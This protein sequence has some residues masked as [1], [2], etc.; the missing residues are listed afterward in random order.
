MSTLRQIPN[1]RLLRARYL[2][3]ALTGVILLS[4]C[5]SESAPSSVLPESVPEG[6]ETPTATGHL[7]LADHPEYA[8]WSLFPVG[9]TVV[10]KKEVA[11][12]FGTVRVT[13]TL[14][15]A[16]KTAE[17]VVV[18]TQVT[19]DRAGEPVENPPQR[20][21]FPAT[22]RVP[23]GMKRDQFLL[24]SLKAKSIGEENRTACGEEYLA[25]IFSWNEVNEA[26]PM[27]VKLWR[28]DDIPGR[29]LRQEINGRNHESVEEVVEIHQPGE[30]PGPPRSFQSP[31][32]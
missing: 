16:E 14:R 22:F 26:G 1:K 32:R 25:E 7:P 24:P 10:R 23:E 6:Y 5:E 29:I 11:N 12:D 8:N 30:E 18:E 3:V 2:P 4:G 20:F 27:A 9:T 19:V 28:S 15:L 17:K 21:E 13:T 31:E